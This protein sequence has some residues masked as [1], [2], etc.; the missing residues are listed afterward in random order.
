MN[1]VMESQNNQSM[2][3][4]SDRLADILSEMDVPV[5]RRG[6][7]GWLSRNL[8]VRNASHKDFD[9]ATQIIRRLM[10]RQGRS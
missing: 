1:L 9:E 8:A 3:D 4:D 2:S 10:R 5:T 7:L 6:D